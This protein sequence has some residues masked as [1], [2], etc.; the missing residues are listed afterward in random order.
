[1]PVAVGPLKMFNLSIKTAVS[2]TVFM[3]KEWN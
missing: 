2:N 1:M 3:I